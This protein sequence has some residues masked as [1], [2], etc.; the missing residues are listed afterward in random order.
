MTQ[1]KTID[2]KQANAPETI[3]TME[4]AGGPCCTPL[5]GLPMDEEQ[6]EALAKSFKALGHPVR[7]QI[8]DILS[9]HSGEA[10]VCDIESQFELSQ[11]TISH[12]LRVLRNAG[13]VQYRQKGLWVYYY[14]DIDNLESLRLFLDH[15]VDE[16][17]S[18]GPVGLAASVSERASTS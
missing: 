6:A 14:L 2:P 10:C 1:S 4:L 11:P 17:V 16:Q 3:L 13:L 7:L 15:A 18:R 12:H 8:V 5:E 9:R